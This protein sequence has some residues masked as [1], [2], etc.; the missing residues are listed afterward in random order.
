MTRK[1]RLALAALLLL[2]LAGCVEE[3]VTLPMFNPATASATPAAP[4]AK[5][6]D[7]TI[8]MENRTF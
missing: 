8:R 3:D 2:P 6:P 4:S 5:S 7:A 1:I